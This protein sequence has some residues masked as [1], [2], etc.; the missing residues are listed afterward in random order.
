MVQFCLVALCPEINTFLLGFPIYLPIDIYSSFEWSFAFCG[1]F[2]EGYDIRAWSQGLA[3][4]RKVLPSFLTG[5]FQKVCLQ[6]QKCFSSAWSSLLLWLSFAFYFIFL[7]LQRFVWCLFIIF[8]SFMNSLIMSAILVLLKY[9][10]VFFKVM[11]L[12]SF[13]NN[14]LIFLF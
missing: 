2:F 9:L 14:T 12:N 11:I 8:T 7:I 5:F 13:S 10:F 3:F 4:A 1:N 6:D